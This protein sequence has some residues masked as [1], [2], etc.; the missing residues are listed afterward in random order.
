MIDID[1]EKCVYSAEEEEIAECRA[2]STAVPLHELAGPWNTGASATHSELR[3][4]VIR[5]QS[6]WRWANHRPLQCWS[7]QNW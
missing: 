4:P 5:R 6:N 7:W 1:C 2:N 3:S